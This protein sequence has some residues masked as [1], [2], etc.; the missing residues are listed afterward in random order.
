MARGLLKRTSDPLE[1]VRY[2]AIG[3]GFHRL[4]REF[5][6]Q[7]AYKFIVLCDTD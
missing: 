4:S 2:A 5:G 3:S 1:C 6:E 7:E